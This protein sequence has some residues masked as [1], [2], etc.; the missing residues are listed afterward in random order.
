[1]GESEVL[2]SRNLNGAVI[3]EGEAKTKNDDIDMELEWYPFI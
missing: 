1:V 3:V 2:G